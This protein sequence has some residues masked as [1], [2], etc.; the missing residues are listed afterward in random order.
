M[1]RYGDYPRATNEL[2]ITVILSRFKD[3]EKVRGYY[4]GLGDLTQEEEGR[5]KDVEAK[6]KK[7]IDASID[8]PSLL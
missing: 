3:V 1:I 5:Q 7:L 2:K 4:D 6:L 8:V